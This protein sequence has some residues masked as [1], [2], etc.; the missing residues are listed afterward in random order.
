MA[1]SQVEI[2]SS[3]PFG[4]VLRDHNR[5]D[6]CIAESNARATQTALQKNLKNLVRNHLQTCISIS[7]ETSQSQ[8]QQKQIHD[9]DSSW[10]SNNEEE[11]RKI[12][13]KGLDNNGDR[14]SCPMI[15]SRQAWILG[16]W[17]AKDAKEMVPAIEA[18]RTNDLDIMGLANSA[19]SSPG[20][21]TSRREDNTHL[22][23]SD[24]LGEISSLGASSLV[25]IWERRLSKSYSMNSSA[26]RCDSGISGNEIASSEASSVDERF[27]VCPASE[28]SASAW[29][30]ERNAQSDQPCCSSSQ[31]QNLDAGESERVRVADIIRRLTAANQAQSS[32]SSLSDDNYDNE[33]YSST[34]ASPSREQERSSISDQ[35]E[36]R[37]FSPVRCSPR[38]RGR[39]A[40]TDL[41]MQIERDRHGEL[42]KLVDRKVVSRFSQ[43]GRI[44]V[45]Q[46]FHS[47]QHLQ[48]NNDKDD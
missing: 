9:P 41:L 14:N 46:S 48:G 40:F 10:I 44:Q 18:S 42:D 47:F 3:A 21:S 35:L 5:R 28:D 2:A 8:Q 29:N 23:R 16:R 39:Q 34:N 6:R 32:F 37:G 11:E 1:S 45:M 25:Q 15:S 33:H 31:E 26:S 17:A 13:N 4:C 36:H 24:S 20:P 22:V 19:T 7:P 30:S 38:I 27:D 43:R 12:P